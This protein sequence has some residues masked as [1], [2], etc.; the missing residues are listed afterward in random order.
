MIK[1]QLA[2]GDSDSNLETSSLVTGV[3]KDNF[4]GVTGEGM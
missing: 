2:S 4:F 1:S 3:K